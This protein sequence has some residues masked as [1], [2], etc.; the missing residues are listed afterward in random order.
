MWYKVSVMKCSKIK[1]VQSF[2]VT[3]VFS[4][5]SVQA[6]ATTYKSVKS[7]K[8]EDSKVWSPSKN[9]FAKGNTLQEGDVVIISHDV[10]FN[11]DLKIKG[12][13]TI[14]STGSFKNLKKDIKI[15]NNS[16]SGLI[17]NFGAIEAGEI[18][19]RG[20]KSSG[21]QSPRLLNYGTILIGELE[22]RDKNQEEIVN[23]QSG[24]ITVSKTKGDAKGEVEIENRFQ[25][26]GTLI[27]D[28]IIIVEGGELE[29]GGDYLTPLV[30]LDRNGS[31]PAKLTKANI[32]SANDKSPN[33]MVKGGKKHNS[34]INFVLAEYTTTGNNTVESK[35]FII[36]SSSVANCG[37]SIDQTPAVGGGNP[38]PVQL[39]YFKG[40]VA[41]RTTILMWE[42]SSELNN[43]K[44]IV[45]RSYDGVIWKHV[46]DMKGA[47]TTNES[48]FYELIDDITGGP[49]FIYY[50]LTQVDFDGKTKTYPVIDVYN[51]N[52][53]KIS[54][55]D[56]EEP[57]LNIYPN[58]T[59]GLL[60]INYSDG[61]MI[62]AVMIVNQNGQIIELPTSIENN[63]ITLNFEGQEK[64]TFSIKI[65][66][67][68]KY[69]FR[70]VVYIP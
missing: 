20:K 27:A 54:D 26:C 30:E 69:Q 13:L 35:D 2:I 62:D 53:D 40:N 46:I 18:E 63:E 44:F 11:K 38:L 31:K 33:F 19:L 68:G 64:G 50:K 34:L 39:L 58:P 57:E 14:D 22:L 42:T 24:V 51:Q 32:C 9:P 7:G 6:I 61:T 15:G 43:E 21:A 55:E 17:T 60:H 70:R 52:F 41:N 65:L 10:T 29:C 1:L 36:D 25:N 66:S 16:N 45:E 56:L 5:F 3:V 48:K 47:G 8:A 4:V 28:K 12:Q 59:R 23:Y 37:M 67:G 49:E